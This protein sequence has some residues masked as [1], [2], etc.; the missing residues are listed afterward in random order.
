MK[1]AILLIGVFL[2]S[3]HGRGITEP[4][5]TPQMYRTYDGTSEDIVGGQE[6]KYK[7]LKNFQ[8]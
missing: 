2:I 1:A 7:N 3:V 4:V 8:I 5:R 6:S